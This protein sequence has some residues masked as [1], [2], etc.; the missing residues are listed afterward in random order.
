MN[1]ARGLSPDMAELRRVIGTGSSA[2]PD[3]LNV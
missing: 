3:C 2:V 1:W